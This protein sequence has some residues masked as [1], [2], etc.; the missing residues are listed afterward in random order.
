MN[1][2]ESKK[3]VERAF[4]ILKN[5]KNVSEEI[6][7]HLGVEEKYRLKT[8]TYPD[9]KWSL[10][11]DEIKQL[12]E[13]GILTNNGEFNSKLASN[14]KLTPLEKLLYALAWK[15][16]DLNKI[17]HIVYGIENTEREAEK[18]IVFY[19][20]GRHLTDH[21]SEPIVDQ[22]IMRAFNTHM[23]DNYDEDEI[24]KIRK[25]D[26]ITDYNMVDQYKKW[27]SN[28]R[29]LNDNR[30]VDKILFAIGKKIKL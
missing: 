23:T 7:N 19:Q 17:K 1:N 14:D 12:K 25:N 15:N 22:H 13:N 6:L 24:E 3:L 30:E 27:L 2:K 16:A 29:L 20:F 26:K 21:L 10:K 4:E 9:I 8:N 5:E 11:N 28:E 18:A